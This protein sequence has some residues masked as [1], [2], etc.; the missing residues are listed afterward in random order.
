MLC[1]GEVRGDGPVHNAEY[2]P[3]S[4]S[5]KNLTNVMLSEDNKLISAENNPCLAMH[6]ALHKRS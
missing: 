3:A 6:I 1:L 4:G 5:T 2:I